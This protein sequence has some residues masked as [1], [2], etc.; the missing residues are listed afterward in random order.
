[1]LS[2]FCPRYPTTGGSSTG[3]RQS[4]SRKGTER[5]AYTPLLRVPAVEVSREGGGFEALLDVQDE[6]VVLA[7]SRRV[8]PDVLLKHRADINTSASQ[9][10]EDCT[11]HE[12]VNIVQAWGLYKT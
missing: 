5:V 2:N 12:D 8:R 10:G 4:Q 7:A 6:R 11:R 3:R 1:M 9:R